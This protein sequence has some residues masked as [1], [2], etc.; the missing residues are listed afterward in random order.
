MPI[1]HNPASTSRTCL[2]SALALSTLALSN[3]INNSSMKFINA[4]GAQVAE[5]D[6]DQHKF[7]YVAFEADDNACAS[8]PAAWWSGS[9]DSVCAKCETGKVV[10]DGQDGCDSCTAGA[11]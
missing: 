5:A 2:R 6:Q 10:S 8:C 1:S 7:H 4:A 3:K 9:G 11:T